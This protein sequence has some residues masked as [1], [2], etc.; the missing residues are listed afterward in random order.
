MAVDTEDKR[1][2]AC[3]IAAP[4]KPMPPVA[5]GTINQADRQHVA[6]CYRGISAIGAP[7]G[8]L[9]QFFSS[10]KWGGKARKSA[11]KQ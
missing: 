3:C 10:G 5:N 4:W 2:S 7:E 6:F 9:N 11:G 8:G 1:R